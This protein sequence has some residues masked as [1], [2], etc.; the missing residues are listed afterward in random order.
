M[1]LLEYY[2]D[3]RK[4]R[5]EAAFILF[6][7][8]ASGVFADAGGALQYPGQSEAGCAQ[9]ELREESCGLFRIDVPS[10]SG[11]TVVRR[12]GYAAFIVPVKGADGTGGIRRDLYNRNR[13]YVAS[14]PSVDRSW[15]ETDAMTRFTVSAL[16]RAGVMSARGDLADVLDVYGEKQTIL[17]RTKAAIREYLGAVVIP[18]PS[19][20]W[21]LDLDATGCARGIA[22]SDPTARAASVRRTFCYYNP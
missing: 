3:R 13:R 15:L 22:G 7:D 21:K 2:N 14:L 9:A 20:M 1:L 10:L 16:M 5:V 19:A 12:R 8:R 11:L 4:R 6:R 17:G 18:G